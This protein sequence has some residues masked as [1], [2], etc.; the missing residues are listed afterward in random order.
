[1]ARLRFAADFRDA[2]ASLYPTTEEACITCAIVDAAS[3]VRD[4]NFKYLAE[5]KG[6]TVTARFGPDG[7]TLCDPNL[8]GDGAEKVFEKIYGKAI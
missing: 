7:V 3:K 5:G 1:M 2:V 6:A 4:L 8:A